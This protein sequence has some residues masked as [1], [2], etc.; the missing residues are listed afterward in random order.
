MSFAF[1]ATIGRAIFSK[2]GLGIMIA[3][4]LVLAVLWFEDWSYDRGHAKATADLTPTIT[5]LEKELKAE[6]AVTSAFRQTVKNQEEAHA[7]ALK[8]LKEEQAEQAKAAQKSLDARDAKIKQLEKRN[9]EIRKFVSVKADG[10]CTVPAGFVRFH[11]L[12]AEGAGDVPPASSTGQASAVPGSGSADDDAPS[13]VA[14]S[15]VAQTVGANYTSC[16]GVRETLE[17]WQ[18]WYKGAFSSWKKA[19][20]TQA[21]F[22]TVLPPSPAQ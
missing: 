2:V 20:E 11:N 12:Q 8:T 18:T 4:A 7:A 22:T 6:K 17:L 15:T 19:V 14:L 16:H 9:E 1:L 21:N 5:R 13:G 3:I 10:A